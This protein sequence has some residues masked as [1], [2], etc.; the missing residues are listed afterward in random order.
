MQTISNAKKF[1]Q[2]NIPFPIGSNFDTQFSSNNIHTTII[3][4]YSYFYQ[5]TPSYPNFQTHYSGIR[6]LQNSQQNDQHQRFRTPTPSPGQNILSHL[7]LDASQSSSSSVAR[8]RTPTPSP[9][10]N[11]LA[12]SELEASQSSSSSLANLL[13]N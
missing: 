13:L 1:R 9:G 12:H 6:Q 8:F 2:Q 3:N 11:I 7:E 4:Q 5:R 10:Q